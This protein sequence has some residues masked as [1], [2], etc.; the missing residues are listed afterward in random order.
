[1]KGSI[2]VYKLYVKCPEPRH[3]GDPVF[4]Q[5]LFSCPYLHVLSKYKCTTREIPISGKRVKS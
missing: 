4:G 3:L 1:M 5:T 2:P